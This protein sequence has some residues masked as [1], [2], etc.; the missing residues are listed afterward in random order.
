[1][2]KTIEGPAAALWQVSRDVAGRWRTIE[3]GFSA[4]LLA[5]I[6]I[7]PLAEGAGRMLGIGNLVPGSILLVQHFT[8]LVAMAGGALAARDNRLLALSTAAFVPSR[9]KEPAQVFAAAIGVAVCTCLAYAA[10]TFAMV[11]REAEDTVAFGLPVWVFILVMAPGFAA[12]GARMAWRSS[13]ALP[14][15][16]LA[17]AGHPRSDCAGVV[18]DAGRIAHPS[19]CR[20]CAIRPARS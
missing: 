15:K 20:D 3:N 8:L 7:L 13:P 2:G 18:G 14:G 19:I 12:I 10:W 4:A 9:L 5:V 6:A 11:E 17:L 16:A 1:M